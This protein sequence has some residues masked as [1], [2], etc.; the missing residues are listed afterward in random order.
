MAI[1]LFHRGD[2]PW[3]RRTGTGLR[4]AWL[5][6]N[7]YAHG[8]Q[9]T[10]AQSD[11]RHQNYDKPAVIAKPI[12]KTTDPRWVLAA[13]TAESLEGPL[14]TPEK[15]Q[16]LLRLAHLL[17]LTPFDANL[18]IA[19]VQDQARRGYTAAACLTAG[20]EQLAMVDSVQN[21]SSDRQQR[22]ATHI[23][24]SVTALFVL[25]LLLVWWWL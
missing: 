15:R 8:V 18:V 9:L 4:R 20:R 3:W 19:I 7:W 12:V 1:P 21:R 25:E 5:R 23:V 2:T 14:L 10:M 17:A 13:R 24:W 11:P 22:R 6:C 16:R